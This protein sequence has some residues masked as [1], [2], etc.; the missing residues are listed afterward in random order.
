MSVEKVWQ[1]VIISFEDEV[2]SVGLALAAD[3]NRETPELLCDF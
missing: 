1:H 3:F 2:V